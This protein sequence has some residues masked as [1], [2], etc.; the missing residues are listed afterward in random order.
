MVRDL[1]EATQLEDAE[2]LKANNLILASLFI[3][4]LSLW[5]CRYAIIA[6]I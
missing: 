2:F 4:D 3:P 1:V 5:Q 6:D